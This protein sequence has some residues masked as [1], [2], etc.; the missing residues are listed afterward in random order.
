MNLP[1]DRRNDL[2]RLLGDDGGEFGA[3]YRRL[4]RVDPPRRLDRAVLGD[5]A[6]AVHGRPPR[7]QRWLVGFGSAAGIVL[8]AG[9]AWHVGQD[10]LSQHGEQT[11]RFA[12][13][14]VP[15][16][17][18]TEPRPRRHM[19]GAAAE[20]PANAAPAPAL[21]AQDQVPK[22]T[23]RVRKPS[24]ASARPPAA[25]AETAPA[26]P[27]PALAPRKAFPADTH[28]DEP[29][30]STGAGDAA[31]P[32]PVGTPHPADAL[33]QRMRATPAAGL[34]PPSTSIELRR[35][36]QLAPDRWLARIRQLLQ[37]GRRQQ[38][39]ESLRLFRQAHPQEPIPDALRVL[40]D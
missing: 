10:A 35:D 32:A 19:P 29:D 15:V 8:A 6:R 38:A 31:A 11:G 34:A 17:P 40:L 21:P 14:V 18:I 7:R 36:T 28:R 22:P 3:L 2:D 25:E 39:T 1:R 13:N 26:A 30:T 16:E 23:A 27:A 9:I 33:D 5:A 20:L 37:Q 24:P 12:P 4:S